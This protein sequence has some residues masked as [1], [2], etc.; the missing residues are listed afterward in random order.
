MNAP[1]TSAA[2]RELTLDPNDWEQTRR[3]AHAMLDYV[4]DL[5]RDIRNRPVWQ[6]PTDAARRAYATPLPRDG[7]GLEAACETFRDH[8]VP[9]ALGNIHPRFWGWVCGS[10]SVPGVVAEMLAA[11]INGHASFGDQAATHIERQ[12]ISWFTQLVGYPEDAS[13]I[14]VSSGSVAEI[15]AMIVARDAI[16]E[17][18]CGSGVRSV[19]GTPLAYASEQVHNSLDKAIGII[20]LGRDNLRK[21]AVD[22]DYRIRVDE[23]ERA[24]EEDLKAGRRPMCVVATAGTVNTGATDDLPAV[25]DIAHRYGMWMHV[26]AAFGIALAASPRHRSIIDGI[27]Q[28]DSISFDFHKWFHVPYDAACTLVRDSSAHRRSFAP[29]AAYLAPLDGGIPSGGTSFGE[30]GMDLSRGFR[31]LKV[32]MT[33]MT[34]GLDHLGALVDQ[35]IEQARYLCQLVD[36]EPRLTLAAPAP[37]N[38][39]TFRYADPQADDKTNDDI[40]REIL[41]GLQESGIAAPSHTVLDGRF[42]IRVA[43]TNHRSRREDFQVLVQEAVRLGQQSALI[44]G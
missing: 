8:I 36:N 12:V 7:K 33:F 16:L 29:H 42:A 30:L 37:L 40:T 21:I 23:L 1:D 4:I 11:G 6:R 22:Q 19:P 41:I 27:E 44:I 17:G 39:V 25:A 15:T 9:H 18:V 35:N 13:G 34:Y 32:W 43:I 14:L 24:V 10:G 3:A 31:A 2:A 26:D 28:A 20:G 38:I 5:Q